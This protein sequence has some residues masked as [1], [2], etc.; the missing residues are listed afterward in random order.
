MTHKVFRRCAMALA[1]L[2]V[3]RRLNMTSMTYS[4]AAAFI[5][6]ALVT[7]ASSFAQDEDE[8][9]HSLTVEC[10][11]SDNPSSQFEA[12]SMAATRQSP[13]D[14][15]S[16]KAV[17][18]TVTTIFPTIFHRGQQ[19]QAATYLVKVGETAECAFPSGNKV[20]AKVGVASSS[21]FGFCGGDPEV[22]ASVWVN[23]RK[24]ASQVWF[25]GYCRHEDGY[26]DVSLNYSN[27]QHVSLEKCHS[28]RP[29][30]ASA[31][32]PE[33]NSS[34]AEPL[35]VCVDY[36]DFSSVQRDEIEYPRLGQ[37]VVTVGAVVLLTGQDKVCKAVLEELDADFDTFEHYSKRSMIRLTLPNWSDVEGREQSI[38]DFDNDGKLDRVRRINNS[39]HYMDGSELL[40]DPGSTS[41]N[42]HQ[43]LDRTENGAWLLPC[44][45]SATRYTIDECPPGSPKTDEAGFWMGTKSKPETVYFRARYLSLSPFAFAGQSFVGVSGQGEA[46]NFV[47]VVKPMRNQTFKRMCLF[48]RVQENF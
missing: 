11:Y 20:R 18:K 2:L 30:E 32:N 39:S 24:I 34:A 14:A 23:E 9:T 26:P 25:A 10:S 37:K 40:V 19:S 15:A 22:F 31:A 48:Q 35:S 13:A 29:K 42:L 45:M 43:P 44:Q 33:A 8:S 27:N 47:A 5:L 21:A 3:V 41:K 6:A 36:P 38:F 4:A 7:P 28:L 16:T 12:V 17:V 46:E 1:N